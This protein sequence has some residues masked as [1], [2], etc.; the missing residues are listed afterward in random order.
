[1]DDRIMSPG[2]LVQ[3]GPQGP[4]SMTPNLLINHDDDSINMS[5]RNS[6]ADILSQTSEGKQRIVKQT[7]G[8]Q[9]K[10][11]AKGQAGKA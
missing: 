8:G 3:N 2:Q 4:R 7:I 9:A 5:Q 10:H 1:M 6:A 11:M